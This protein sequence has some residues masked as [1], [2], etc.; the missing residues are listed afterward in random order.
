MVSFTRPVTADP[1]SRRH[2]T[3]ETHWR[4]VTSNA[5]C[6]LICSHAN[7]QTSKWPTGGIR[8]S[9]HRSPKLSVSKKRNPCF[10][11]NS[12][13]EK[14]DYKNDLRK[15]SFSKQNSWQAHRGSNQLL[16]INSNENVDP[17]RAPQS[18]FFPPH[19]PKKLFIYLCRHWNFWTGGPEKK[20]SPSKQ[21]VCG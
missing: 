1:P 3:P 18:R 19:Y 13:E 7:P 16:R 20:H 4:F 12:T 5:E 21:S 9:L 11:I 8:I 14:Y 6:Q 2:V 10:L 15:S 17:S